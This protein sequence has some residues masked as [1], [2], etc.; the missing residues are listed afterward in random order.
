MTQYD[1]EAINFVLRNV[2]DNDVKFIRL[3]FSDIVGNLKGVAIT[4]E[5][6]ESA[7]TRGMG[8]DGSSIDGFARSKEN[9]MFINILNKEGDNGRFNNDRFETIHETISSQSFEN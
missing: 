6:L 2:R 1:S 7:M 3:W 9:D 5:E 8:V 4:S